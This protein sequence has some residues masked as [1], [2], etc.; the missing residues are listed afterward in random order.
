MEAVKGACN[1]LCIKPCIKEIC[2][3][4]NLRN[5]FIRVF[6]RS[7][8]LIEFIPT[9]DTVTFSYIFYEIFRL[10]RSEWMIV[11]QTSRFQKSN[12]RACIFYLLDRLLK[13]N[14]DILQS[15][16][17]TELEPDSNDRDDNSLNSFARTQHWR[18]RLFTSWFILQLVDSSCVIDNTI[19]DQILKL[20]TELL[21]EENGQPLQLV[22]IGLIGKLVASLIDQKLDCNNCI[23][24]TVIKTFD[25]HFTDSIFVEMFCRAL[26][27]GHRN[28]DENNPQWAHGVSEVLRDV[29]TYLAGASFYPFERAGRTSDIFV[30]H[31][32]RLIENILSI[33]SR[34]FIIQSAGVF[35][36][37]A[38]HFADAP[39]SEDQKNQ[40]CTAIEIFT[41]VCRALLNNLPVEAWGLNVCIAFLDNILPSFPL[42][43]MNCLYDGI[44]YIVHL[45]PSD[46]FYFLTEWTISK[47]SE[48]LWQHQVEKKEA[49]QI[50]NSDTTSDGFSFQ[51]KLLTLVKSILVEID[52]QPQEVWYHNLMNKS[53]YRVQSN[54][55]S[56][57]DNATLHIVYKHL[58]PNVLNSIG[59]P[60]EQC[61]G[62]IAGLLF[63][64]C[65]MHRK[66]VGNLSPEFD[67]S[68]EIMST[69]EKYAHNKSG[70]SFSWKQQCHCRITIGKFMLAF[71]RWGDSKFY[72][73]FFLRI[74]P[75]AFESLKLSEHKTTDSSQLLLDAEVVKIFRYVLAE[76]ASINT[77]AFGREFEIDNVLATMN[78]VSSSDVWKVRQVSAHFLRCFQG[79]HK[80]IFSP[81]QTE[82][83]T[84]IVATLL[85][86]ERREVSSAALAALIGI[87]AVTPTNDVALLVKKF[88]K[89][90]LCAI[91]QRKRVRSK[92][93][94]LGMNELDCLRTQQRSVFFLCAAVLSRPYTTPSF[95]P[96]AL[97]A[98][99]KH[100]FER[101]AP[102]TVRE[103][104]KKCCSEYKR[105]HIDQWQAHRRQFSQEQLE[106]LE[107]VVSTPHYYA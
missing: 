37:I 59:H 35:L 103:T 38:R 100:S 57:E 14:Y 80:F 9:E 64:I 85:S 87:L 74:L 39:V 36:D 16:M 34:D 61:R 84:N 42:S 86:D 83:A 19:L 17:N 99:S 73:E 13:E 90:S 6:C 54:I 104:V 89:L 44:R 24:N 31:H 55:I 72:T 79:C 56:L 51:L 2:T 28:N 23:P 33:L 65:Q 12:Y 7:E 93:E 106:S 45:Q 96:I 26:S 81:T 52:I 8:R 77:I 49:S 21:K 71:V 68:N 1:I 46:H 43:M 18:N 82:Y 20:C 70:I 11:P 58:L 105:T 4:G 47:L 97:A 92:D 69:L 67:L 94:K 107:D 25:Q 63:R 40:Q 88:E 30:T 95:V 91:S 48:H 50:G 3:N 101:N 62:S 60:Y 29:G 98:I 75:I 78:Q 10:V 53:N 41:G 15:D 32:A 66:F 76:L 27:Y 22:P 102:L 5:R